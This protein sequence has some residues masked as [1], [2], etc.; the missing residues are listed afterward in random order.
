MSPPAYLAGFATEDI[1]PPLFFG[2]RV[3]L[4]GYLRMYNYARK[5]LH[6]L[7]ARAICIRHPID[8]KNSILFISCDLVGFQYTKAKIARKIIS[9]LT[10]VP[11]ANIIFHFTHS[12][13]SPEMTGIMPNKVSHKANTD[14]Q[15]HV[16]KPL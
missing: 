3:R 16:V 1:T 6:A 2:E 11:I 7:K 13:T 5:V 14:I 4:G 12:H 8:P 10:G 9:H 15:Y